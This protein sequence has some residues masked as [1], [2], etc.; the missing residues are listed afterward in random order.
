[1]I[2]N[3]GNYNKN[4]QLENLTNAERVKIKLHLS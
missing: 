4:N 3:V 2:S 1:M